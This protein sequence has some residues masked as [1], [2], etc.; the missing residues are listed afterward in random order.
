[1]TLNTERITSALNRVREK[2]VEKDSLIASLK[3]ERDA[4]RA[5][6]DKLSAVTFW[7][8][9]DSGKSI[10]VGDEV[11]YFGK[12]YRCKQAHTKALLRSPLNSEYWEAVD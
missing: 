7:A 1:M 10:A 9:L 11:R 2:M 3:A 4:I 8:E 6:W 12:Y 5:A